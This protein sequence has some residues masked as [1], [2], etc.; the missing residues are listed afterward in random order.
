[1]LSTS[2]IASSF[3]NASAKL[4]HAF[5]FRDV[6]SIIHFGSFE[7]NSSFNQI[8]SLAQIIQKLSTHLI[9]VFFIVIVSVPC[10]ETVAQSFAT[11]THCHSSRFDQPQTI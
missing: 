2:K 3:H 6:I 11:A 8:S 9:A 7:G 1:L 5:E 10:H 4:V